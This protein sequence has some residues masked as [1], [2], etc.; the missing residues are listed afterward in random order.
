VKAALYAGVFDDG[1][2]TV[3]NQVRQLRELALARSSPSF[4][5]S[6]QK[7]GHGVTPF[8]GV[9]GWCVWKRLR[10]APYGAVRAW[11]NF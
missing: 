8:P 6:G 2:Q 1:R 11:W 10:S 4:G 5:N 3:E 7:A 9:R